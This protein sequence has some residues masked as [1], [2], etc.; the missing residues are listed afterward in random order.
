MVEGHQPATGAVL[1]KSEEE[2]RDRAIALLARV[3]GVARVFPSSDGVENE[4]RVLRQARQQLETLFLLVVVGEFNSGKS[5][6]I[7][8]LVGEPIMPEGVTPTTA[9]IHLLAVS[10]THLR[11]HETVLDIVCRLLLE[12]QKTGSN[13]EYHHL[14]TLM[15]AKHYV[16]EALDP[17][18]S[19]FSITNCLPTHI[20][21][22]GVHSGPVN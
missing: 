6:F 22:T 12:K 20:R 8:A 15:S 2:L 14:S 1:S 19:A 16:W 4:L 9:M 17:G 5:A 13:T 10:Y 18:L 3:E 21:P 7:N 11:A